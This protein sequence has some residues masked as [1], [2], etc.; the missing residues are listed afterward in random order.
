[1]FLPH[2][3]FRQAF[4]KQN[5]PT[6]LAISNILSYPG[7]HNQLKPPWRHCVESIKID[8]I[9]KL[10][11]QDLHHRGTPLPH[12]QP[13]SAAG[14]QPTAAAFPSSFLRSSPSARRCPS[15]FSPVNH[16]L[17]GVSSREKRAEWKGGSRGIEPRA[18]AAPGLVHASPRFSALSAL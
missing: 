9:E 15:P 4:L 7:W 13:A 3:L 6:P 10:L 5:L 11:G 1:M 8:W 2:L 12:P 14:H 17:L 16:P 18:I